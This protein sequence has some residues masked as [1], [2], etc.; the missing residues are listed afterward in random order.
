MVV[1]T[2]LVEMVVLTI[3]VGMVISSLLPEYSDFLAKLNLFP[4][5]PV[6]IPH[7]KQQAFFDR[8]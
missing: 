7:T 4:Y 3:L 2:I 1:L 5:L 6:K 8:S